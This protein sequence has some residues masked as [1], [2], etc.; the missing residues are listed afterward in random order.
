MI[1]AIQK[2]VVERIVHFKNYPQVCGHSVTFFPARSLLC[3]NF[4]SRSK[5]CYCEIF[6]MEIEIKNRQNLTFFVSSSYN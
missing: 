3:A 4:G 5:I 2:D 1:A 6:V